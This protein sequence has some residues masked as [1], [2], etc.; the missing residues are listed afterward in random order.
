[1]ISAYVWDIGILA[2]VSF[3]H[4]RSVEEQKQSDN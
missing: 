1:M 3:R 2:V 4:G